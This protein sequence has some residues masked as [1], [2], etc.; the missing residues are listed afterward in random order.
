S[1]IAPGLYLLNPEVPGYVTD[2][3]LTGKKAYKA[4]DIA[5]IRLSKGGVITGQ[6]TDNLGQP[7]IGA[8]I[9]AQRLRDGKGGRVWERSI[10]QRNSETDDQGVYRV[11]GLPSG[12]YVIGTIPASV[13]GFSRMERLTPSPVYYPSGTRSAAKEVSVQVGDEIS[14]IN[15]RFQDNPGHTISGTISGTAKTAQ[16]GDDTGVL[17]F[18]AETKEIVSAAQVDSTNNFVFFA[19]PDGEYELFARI[20][21][22]G[23]QESYGSPAQQVTIKGSDVTSIDLRMIKYGSVAGRVIIEP[24][25][26]GESKCVPTSQSSVEEILLTPK[27][28]LRNPR[29]INSLTSASSDWQFSIQPNAKGEFALPSL[30]PDEYRLEANLPNENWFV[31]SMTLPASGA[32]KTK[33]DAARSPINLKSGEKISN[34]EI[35]V[36]EGAASLSGRVPNKEAKEGGNRPSRL[37]VFMI[38]AEAA[39]ADDVLRYRE[40]VIEKNGSFEFK[41]LAPG[42]YRLLARS[43]PDTEKNNQRPTAFDSTER[44]RLRKEAEAANNEIELKPCQRVKDHVLRW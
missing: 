43:I 28:N 25:L 26:P 7:L 38:P 5:S 35:T 40:A 1:G 41:Y 24:A 34:L 33:T 39:A 15:I 20:G 6:I 23:S 42:K 21:G 27:S 12:N 29:S 9:I 14:G 30:E 32:A 31:R 18:D 19:V 16:P 11:Y 10:W 44:I 22:A 2:P 36:A 8:Q 3:S 37:R 13:D 17:L 4:G